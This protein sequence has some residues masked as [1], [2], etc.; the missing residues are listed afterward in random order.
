MNETIV[1][2][3]GSITGSHTGSSTGAAVAPIVGSVLGGG[4]PP[5]I[6]GLAGTGNSA[7]NSAISTSVPVI[8]GLAHNISG[9][10]NS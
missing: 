8:D 6:V 9:M 5:T 1:G 2:T 4:V 7:I 10:F 3:V